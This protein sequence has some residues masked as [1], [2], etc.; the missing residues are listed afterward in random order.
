MFSVAWRLLETALHS[1]WLKSQP[2]TLTYIYSILFIRRPTVTQR[3]KMERID[4]A[5]GDRQLDKVEPCLERDRLRM[6]VSVLEES[7]RSYEVECKASRETVMRLVAEVA[8][9]RRNTAGSAEALDLLRLDLDS[10]LLT[11]RSTDMENQSLAARLEASQRV[12]EAA[13]QEAGCLERQIQ[14]LEGKLQ[15]SQGKNEATKGRLQALLGE[16]GA[17]L[18]LG[19]SMPTEE[20]ILE[21]LGD[22]CNRQE[23]MK[24]IKEEME[25]RLSQVS[26]DVSRQTELHH[27]AL[28]R[29]QLAEQQVTDL[30]DRLQGLEA[31]LMTSD[32]HR[33]GLSHNRQI[34]EQFL[35]QLS[36]RMKVDS[37]ATDLGYDMRLQLI[38]SR[39]EQL[40]KLEGTALVESKTLAH[41]QQRKLKIQKERLESKE[42]HM[43]L[44]RRKVSELEEEKRTRSALAMQ[45]DDAN[46]TARKMQKKVERLQEELGS[47]KVSITELK[48]QLS[49]TNELKLKVLEQSQTN[50]EQSKSLE[51]LEKGKAKVEKKLSTARTDLQSQEHLA[52]EAQQQLT[53]LRQTLA[54]L[55]DRE[56]ELVD[57]RMVVSQMLGLDVTALALPNYEIIKSL[58]SLLHPH[59]DLHHHSLALSWPCPTHHQNHHLLQLQD[60][61]TS[62]S[63]TS[64]S[65]FS[66]RSTGPEALL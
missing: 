12:V 3:S 9:E 53:S 13:K 44:L 2:K 63:V 59:H 39:A 36:E 40:V 32:V 30:S 52:R 25:R 8:R 17:L 29:A 38:L 49:H 46:V 4:T 31:E 28:Q 6:R 19:L 56:R 54:Q 55:T 47:S 51:D 10:A 58:E 64:L 5:T 37:I 20:E 27:S 43:E 57:F 50:V 34:Y 62:G 41:N 66:Q 15:T 33:D 11:K 14:E 21:R 61:D 23:R 26:E 22:L 48:A 65:A 45:R 60:Q 24:A 42:L 16:V 18:Q 7:V 35:E 1:T